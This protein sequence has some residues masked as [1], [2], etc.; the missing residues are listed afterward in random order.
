ME[1]QVGCIYGISSALQNAAL[2]I[3]T[4]SSGFLVLSFGERPVFVS[5][6]V[7]MFLLTIG[8]IFIPKGNSVQGEKNAR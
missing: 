5:L 7:V 4:V 8:A 1:H 2:T 3:T 6:A